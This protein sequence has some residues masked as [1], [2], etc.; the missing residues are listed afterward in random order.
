MRNEA[1]QPLASRLA[2]RTAVLLV[3]GVAQMHEICANR[4]LKVG[5]GLLAC[6]STTMSAPPRHSC[7]GIDDLCTKVDATWVDMRRTFRDRILTCTAQEQSHLHH[8]LES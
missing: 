2:D 1:L 6:A 8:E 4:I 3:S 5:V 7:A